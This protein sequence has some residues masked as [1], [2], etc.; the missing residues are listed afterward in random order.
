M[1]SVRR[2]LLCLP[3]LTLSW[4]SAAQDMTLDEAIATARGGSVKALEAK[5]EFISDYWA[6][7]AYKASRLP[8]IYLYGSLGNFDR[9]LR[10]L[11]NYETGEMLYTNNYNM[12]NSIGVRARQ[13]IPFTG[14]TVYLYTDLTRL[15]QFGPQRGQTW[16]AQPVTIS[17]SQ[18]L[19]AYNQFKWDRLISPKEYEKARKVYLES[20][21]DVS[22]S[23]V[24]SFFEVML[25]ERT[26][27]AAVKNYRNTSSVLSIAKERLLIGSITRDD[28]LQLELRSLNDSIAIDERLVELK[29]A[30]MKL[31]S[32]LGYG[33]SVEV[34]AVLEDRLPVIE[35]D[36]GFVLDKSLTNS[37]FS[38]GNSIDL[39]SADAAVAKAKASRGITMELNARFGLSN[40]APELNSTYKDLLDQEVVGLT[41]SIPIFDWGEG[42]GKVMKAKAAADVVKAQVAQAEN[43]LRIR[44]FTA[45]GQF[46][47]QR[48]LCEVSSR[49]VAIA[50]ERYDLVLEKFRSGKVNVT[51]LNTARSENDDAMSKY[52]K[53]MGDFW[54]YYYTMRKLTLY[55][56]IAGRDIEVDY[57]EMVDS[58]EN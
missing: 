47:N 25:A 40:S 2:L 12:Q 17:Y 26:Y 46:N 3:V 51:E 45:V 33:E 31:N 18:P 30:R 36:Y 42:K 21:E 19:F 52:V 50:S 39:L 43:D 23:A 14:G 34:H 57:E 58:Y 28:Y 9:S 24:E 44:I 8:S 32:L 6:W 27:E 41:F 20:M 10:L 54:R 35:M 48:R 37:S 55:D 15:D 7:R 22:L 56:F 4:A 49:A 5:S 11:Q 16:Y 13:N 1:K 29:Q 38:L 53:D